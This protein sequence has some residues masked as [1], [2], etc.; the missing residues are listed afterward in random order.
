MKKLIGILF[1]FAFAACDESNLQ[2]ADNNPPNLAPLSNQQIEIV[3]ASNQFSFE[4]IKKIDAEE[5]DNFFISPL[6]ISYALGMVYNGAEGET[7]QG[8]KQALDFGDLSDEAINLSYKSLRDQILSMDNKVE[9]G[10]ANSIWYKNTF[11]INQDFSDKMLQYYDAKVEGL[12]FDAEESVDIINGWIEDKTND[13]IKDMLNSIP[14]EA[15][16][17]LINAI[18][19]NAEWTFQFDKSA[20]KMEDFLL[21]DGSNEQVEMMYSEG[22][23]VNFSSNQDMNLIDIPYGNQQFQMSILL[24]NEGNTVDEIWQSTTPGTIAQLDAESDTATVELYFPKFEMQYKKNLDNILKS[25]GMEKAFTETAEFPKLL[26]NDLQLFISRVLHQSY[27]KVDEKG[28]EAAAVTVVE[29]SPTSIGGQPKVIKI[30]RPFAFM[31]REKHT[32][33]I[34]FAGKMINPNL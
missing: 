28:T 34:L 23:T 21:E 33:S 1:L 27:L 11:S 3:N 19:F 7:K 6:S 8:I 24:P 20:T 14:P 31:I 25:M 30:D 5:S 2:P 9:L 26:E 22:T 29:I 17:Y 16:M 10:L 15:A 32:G 4:I 18:Y 12:D 13:K